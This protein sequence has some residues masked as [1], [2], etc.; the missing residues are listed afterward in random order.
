MNICVYCASSTTIDE[1]YHL[2]AAEL[3]ELIANDNHTLVYDGGNIG[4]MGTLAKSVHSNN[5]Q[6]VGVIPKP[7]RRLG[8]FV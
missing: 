4:L 3:G 2:V 6:V 7:S 1:R 8:S 5:G